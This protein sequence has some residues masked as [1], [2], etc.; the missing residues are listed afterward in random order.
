MQTFRI[1]IV[2]PRPAELLAG[3]SAK[4]KGN[5][6]RQW[7]ACVAA[8]CLLLASGAGRGDRIQLKNGATINASVLKSDK[9]AVV[10]DLGGQVLRLPRGE[11]VRMDAGPA[12]GN[13][14]TSRP[15]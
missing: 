11:I 10:V 13:G 15:I 3:R 14:A 2:W 6:M 12:P 1:P 8:T 5:R 9:A 7:H 4:G